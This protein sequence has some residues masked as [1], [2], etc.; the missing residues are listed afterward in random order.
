M[1]PPDYDQLVVN[2][3]EQTLTDH[4]KEL[5]VRGLSFCPTSKPPHEHDI[6]TEY[7]HFDRRSRLKHH[8]GKQMVEEGLT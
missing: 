3:S 5:L 4:E 8:F 6:L 7:L 2:I 1:K